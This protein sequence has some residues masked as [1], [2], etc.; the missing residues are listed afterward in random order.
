MPVLRP[1]VFNDQTKT[2]IAWI[3]SACEAVLS[4]D[5]ADAILTKKSTE[6]IN[7]DF[8]MHCKEQHP[9]SQIIG[10]DIPPEDFSQ[11]ARIVREAT[12]D[13]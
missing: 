8:E 7:K 1:S 5:R 10:L 6:Q 2:P 4:L 13:K 11:A 3:C 9:G 12:E